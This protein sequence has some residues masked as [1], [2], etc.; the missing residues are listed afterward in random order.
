MGDV[1]Y[2]LL[3]EVWRNTSATFKAVIISADSDMCARA[4]GWPQ[5]TIIKAAAKKTLANQW[6]DVWDHTA[7]A[8]HYYGTQHISQLQRSILSNI[9]GCDLYNGFCLSRRQLVDILGVAIITQVCTRVQGDN[10]C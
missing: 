7:L 1:D 4:M 3:A 9:R 10:Y 8:R 5:V 2:A 6:L